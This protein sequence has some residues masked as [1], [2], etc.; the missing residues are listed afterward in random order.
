MKNI[1]SLIIG[2][3]VSFVAVS[4]EILDDIGRITMCAYIPEYENIP[5]E[6]SKLLQTKLVQIITSNG[7]ADDKY[8]VRFV[9]TAKVNIVSKDIVAGPP[10][11][12]SQ[13]V[14][15]TLMIGD[16]DA[17]KVMSSITI[18]AIGIG[19][20]EEKAF[21]SA[22]KNINPNDKR[23]SEFIQEAKEKIIIYYNTNCRDIINK[24][25]KQYS[26][27][28]YEQALLLVSNVPD[29][30]TDCYL[31]CSQLA[32]KIYADMINAKGNELLA[33]AKA[34]WAKNPNGQGAKEATNLL[35]QI[36]FAAS[37][38][39]QAKALLA[40]ITSQMKQ[41][42]Q[43]EWELKVQQYNDNIEREKR[44]WEQHV[45][46]YKDK[47]QRIQAQDAERAARQKMIIGAC[48]DVAMQFVGGLSSNYSNIL[49]W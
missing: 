45:Q 14:D 7:I 33:K 35:S 44:N 39:N 11:R 18:P 36:N 27:Q 1:I 5:T 12:I 10:Q 20:S 9:L 34:A 42:D 28:N 8:I 24:A 3:L 31:Q 6:S 43:R 38:Q 30:C 49:N 15:I 32:E 21:I 46:E 37:C 23:I 16:I 2:I 13:K 4:Q 41:I 25:Q 48:R 26:L 17:D 40:D 22:F 29:V 47:Q 19:Q